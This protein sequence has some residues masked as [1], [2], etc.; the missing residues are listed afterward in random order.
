M[1]RHWKDLAERAATPAYS[2]HEVGEAFPVALKN[3]FRE[4]PLEQ[5]RDILGGGKQGSLFK[6]DRAA[7]FEAARGACRGA[8]AGQ[9]LIDSALEAK[10]NGLTGDKAFKSALENAVD[11]H[12]R[13]NCHS[14]E[15]HYKRA[16]W[17]GTADVRDRLTAARGECSFSELATELMSDVS[18]AKGNLRLEKRTGVD[19]GPQ[20]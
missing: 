12:A 19:E 4:A 2:P 3:D 18:A 17:P 10:A 16:G 20:R 11:A 15:E 8:A 1:R 7:H 13:G 5:I 14:I 6:E 9:A